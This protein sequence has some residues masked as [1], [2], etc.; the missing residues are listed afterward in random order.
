MKNRALVDR[1]AEGLVLALADAADYARVEGELAGLRRLFGDNEELKR[2]LANP[3]LTAGRK[4]EIVG[5]L[6]DRLVLSEKTRRF[7]RLLMEHNR[8]DLV[9][10]V[11]EIL[12]AAWAAKL[13]VVSY[14][15]TSAVPLDEGRR[16]RLAA[17]LE[18]LEGAP[19]RLTFGLDPSVLG[20]LRVRKGNL[21]YDASIRG[22][23]D[24]LREHI[25]EG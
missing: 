20:G 21:V 19:V 15:V 10:G 5:D 25:L 6:L 17:E 18:R 22:G 3:L 24:R 8:L 16:R 9:D 7:V 1:Y 23:L 11:L 13:G 14:E 2:A 12:P 4:A